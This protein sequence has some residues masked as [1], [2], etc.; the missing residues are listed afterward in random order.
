[1]GSMTRAPNASMGS[2]T[3]GSGGRESKEGEEEKKQPYI[4]GVQKSGR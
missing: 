4:E 3:W 1:M 2:L